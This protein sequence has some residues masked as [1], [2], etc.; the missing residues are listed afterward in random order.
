MKKI[1]ILI[2]ATIAM[3]SCGNSYKAQVITLNDKIDSV[4]YAYGCGY[5]NYLLDAAMQGEASDAEINE[6]V[7]ALTK[8]YEGKV[9]ELSRIAEVGQNIGQTIKK[10]EENGLMGITAWRLNEK[11]LFQGLANGL[12]QDTTI[13]QRSGAMEFIQTQMQVARTL[14]EVDV[15]K[16]ITAKFVNKFQKVTLKTYNDSINYA[17]GYINGLDLYS[18]LIARDSDVVAATKEFAQYIN[19]G[20]KDKSINPQIVADAQMMGKQFAAN[21][22]KFL[23]VDGV[24]LRFDI[25]RQGLVNG[26]NKDTVM[27]T[28]EFANTYLNAT[29]QELQEMQSRK[30]SEER[31]AAEEAFLKAN[32][33]NPGV[34]VTESGLQYEVI[35]MGRGPKPA[36]EDN[37]KVH[38]HGT[39]LDGTV[40]DSSVDRGQP[41]TFGLTQ[42]IKGWTEG[43]Q[44]MPV[45]S[46]FKFYI[47]YELGYG[48]RAAGSIPPFSMLIFEVE[49][50]SI[51]K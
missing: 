22:D 7:N 10:F 6:L 44:L 35:K 50:L 21:T 23:G 46:K 28:G 36:L 13:M 32:A 9:A 37:V 33:E 17:F 31:I 19:V 26:L 40:F 15:E 47:P 27:M 3:I 39:L 48:G 12:N 24:D 51:E 5:G 1:S 4:N 16:A 20:L 38:Y 43:L 25:I 29:M 14:E 18:G 34:T 2:I 11:L 42:V 8:G 49:L 45:G 41:A 30:S